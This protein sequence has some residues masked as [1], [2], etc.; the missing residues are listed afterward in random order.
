[1]TL[2]TRSITD[3]DTWNSLLRD[4]PDPHLLQCWQWGKL[5]SQFGWQAE[6]LAWLEGDPLSAGSPRA[7][8]ATA[9]AQILTR[10]TGPPGIRL[11]LAYCPRGPV[12]DW[13]TVELRRK[14]LNEM[15][16]H[17]RARGAFLLRIDPEVQLETGEPGDGGDNP[18]GTAVIDELAARGWQRSREQVQ[19]DNT[20][21]VDLGSDEDAL[22]AAMKQKTRYNIR[23]A[24][25]HGVQV[26][27][28][29]LKD[30]D[31]LYRR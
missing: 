1:M 5:K 23:L 4:L 24:S 16:E 26:R 19:F 25:K 8:P 7:R 22:L 12:L 14:V 30:L 28:A 13:S 11:A 6:R 29:G 10:R 9:A 21:L 31:L 20:L 15:I 27:R 3:S 18:V 17:A 2:L